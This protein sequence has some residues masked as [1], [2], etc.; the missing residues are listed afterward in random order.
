[1]MRIVILSLGV[2]VLAGALQAADFPNG[3]PQAGRKLAGAC[4]T[5]HGIDGFAKI[6]IAPHIGGEP[7]AYIDRQLKAFRE[8]TRVH[9]MMSVV[10]KNLDDGKIADLAAWYAGHE[11]TAT[12]TLDES[13][14]PQDC[15]SCHGVDGIAVIE[16]APNLAGE[17]SI[18]VDTQLKAFRTGKRTHDIMSEVAAGMSDADIRAAADWYGS[19]KIEITPLGR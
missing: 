3:D 17:S 7:A 15:V 5:C 14:A 6:P 10:A 12:L 4:R 13:G 18:Y 8:G 9:E 1:M 19:V 2:V 11:V 16:D